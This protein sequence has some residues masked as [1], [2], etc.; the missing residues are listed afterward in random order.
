MLTKAEFTF[1]SIGWTR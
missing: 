1:P